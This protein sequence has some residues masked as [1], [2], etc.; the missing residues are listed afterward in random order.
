M[1]ARVDLHDLDVDRHLHDPNLKQRYVTTLF[2]TIAPKYDRFTHW[3]SFG[4]DRGWKRELTGFVRDVV[5]RGGLVL[6][7][8]CGTGDL[9]SGVLDGP[10]GGSVG[11]PRLVGLDPSGE[12]L[13]RARAR[14]NTPRTGVVRLLRGDMMSIPLADGSADV[15]MVGYGL[16]N[17]PD[18]RVAL[19]EIT[20]VLKPGG[21]LISL[22]FFLPRRPMWRRVFLTY[23]RVAG[24]FYGWWFH[25]EPAA[26]GYIAESI[27]GWVMQGEF[28][29]TLLGAGF[30][31][32]VTRSRLGGGVCIH[33]GSRG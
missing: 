19:R 24:R 21:W 28:D 13:T 29:E 3:F 4:L 10:V 25:R 16:R 9:T 23:L 1:A 7:L 30:G 33:A 14:L 2:D 11:A 27:A 17:V 15:V 18:Y 31:T 26:Y 22:D 20:R 32:L 12:M 8:A 6:D 5:P